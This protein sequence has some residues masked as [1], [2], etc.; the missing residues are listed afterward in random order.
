MK[1]ACIYCGKV[2]EKNYICEKKPKRVNFKGDSL[3]DKFRSSADWKN[4]REE[5][6]KRD[7][8]MCVA[9]YN[10]LAGTVKRLNTENLSVHHIVPIQADYS[11]RLDSDNLITLCPVH[12]ELAESGQISAEVLRK[13][14]PPMC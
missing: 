13:L 1:K 8:Y 10:N 2:H 7:R 6:K 9:C 5:V 12:H 4:K 3:A 11:K 14:V